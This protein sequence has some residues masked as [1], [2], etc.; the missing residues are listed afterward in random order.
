MDR[1]KIAHNINRAR[2]FEP[3]MR[4]IY[5]NEAISIVKYRIKNIEIKSDKD[6][7]H[8]NYLL[9]ILRFLGSEKAN[10]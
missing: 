10:L 8:L 6:I 2:S 5:Y 7:S 3:N 9:Y 4:A 1:L